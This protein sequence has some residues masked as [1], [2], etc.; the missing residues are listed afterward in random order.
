[1]EFLPCDFSEHP[2][3]DAHM[4]MPSNGSCCNHARERFDIAILRPTLTGVPLPLA[5]CVAAET[6]GSSYS[7]EDRR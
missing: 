7:Q 6:N 2:L 1:M 3:R 4:S 5:H